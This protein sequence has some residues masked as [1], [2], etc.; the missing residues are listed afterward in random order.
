MYS[1]VC[2]YH[3]FYVGTGE[4]NPGNTSSYKIFGLYDLQQKLPKRFD[5]AS[6]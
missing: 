5:M 2:K 4:L 1:Q 3:L 6:T